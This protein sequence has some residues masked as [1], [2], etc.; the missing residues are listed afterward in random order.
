MINLLEELAG[1]RPQKLMKEGVSEKTLGRRY[2][3]LD[4]LIEDKSGMHFLNE[5]PTQ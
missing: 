3:E 4:A 5:I 1:G 2:N